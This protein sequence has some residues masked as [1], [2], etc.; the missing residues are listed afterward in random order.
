MKCLNEYLSV[1]FSCSVM[2][3]SLWPHGLQYTGLPCP[4]RTPGTYSDSCLLSRWCH[5][6]ISSSDAPFSSCPQS[7]LASR[8]F[9]VSRLFTWGGQR[10]GAS[11]SAPVLTMN[12]QGWFPLGL[13]GWISL[14]SK[15]LS[16]VFSSTIGRHQFFGAQPFLWSSS[17]TCTWLME[18]LWL[19][20]YGPLSAKWCLCFL[21]S[22]LG[23]S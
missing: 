6:T 11:A 23:L 20:L 16:R 12:I 9:P 4:S 15:E 1:Q 2:S 22:C 5:P 7:F 19:W 8:S 10:M 18:K 13:T 17:H 3:S 21:I 14:L